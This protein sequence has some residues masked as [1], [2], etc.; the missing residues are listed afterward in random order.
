MKEMFALEGFWNW[1]WMLRILC[2][3]AIGAVIGYERHNRSKEAGIRTHAIVALSAALIMIV[4]KYGFYDVLTADSAR[5]AAQVVSG[6]GFLGAG[7]IFVKNDS[8]L[9]LTT[10]A[11]IWATAAVGLCF[12]SG[13]YLMGFLSGLLIL[14]VQ[15]I[16]RQMFTFS[17]PRTFFQ[18]DIKINKDNGSG[19]IKAISDYCKRSGLVQSENKIYK[20]EGEDNGWAILTEVVTSKDI[21]PLAIIDDLKKIPGVVQVELL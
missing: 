4:S 18:I 7:I 10:A 16:A 14:I 8:V 20:S 21:D 5:I 19:A 2:S 9:G 1:E 15:L 13:Y 12:G 17:S 3:A 6:I 11:G